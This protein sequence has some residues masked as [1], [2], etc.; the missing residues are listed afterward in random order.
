MDYPKFPIALYLW[1]WRRYSRRRWCRKRRPLEQCCW[2]VAVLVITTTR[3]KKR[4][5]EFRSASGGSQIGRR[6]QHSNTTDTQTTQSNGQWRLVPSGVSEINIQC[7][8]Q[9]FTNNF[10]VTTFLANSGS[11][12]ITGLVWI[13]S[14]VWV[15]GI[16]YHS[17]FRGWATWPD[18]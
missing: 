18:I 5:R 7:G 3:W 2:S 14:S 13:L 11:S 12:K 4:W 15:I 10:I 17:P 9:S 16:I 1:N 8:R 6:C